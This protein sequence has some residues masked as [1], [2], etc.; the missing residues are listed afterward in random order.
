MQ[1]QLRSL[2][3]GVLMGGPS[4]ERAVSL[5]SGARVLESLL[6]QG[7]RATGLDVDHRIAARLAEND[8]NFA[9]LAVHGRFGEDGALQGL[10]EVAGIPYTGSGV[11]A[12]SVAMNKVA[13]KRLLHSVGVPTAPFSEIDVDRGVDVEARRVADSLGLPLVVKPVAEGSS[14]GVRIV[15]S[16]AALE[17]ALRSD[18]YYYGKVFAEKFVAGCEVTVGILGTNG[19]SRA[20]PVLELRP[21]NQFYDYEAKYT[22][23]MTEFVIP[24]ELSPAATSAVQRAA[25]TTHRTLGC[26]GM[27]RVDAIVTDAGEVSVLEVNTI[28]GLT[29]LSDLPAQAGAAGMSFDELIFEILKSAYVDNHPQRTNAHDDDPSEQRPSP[30]APA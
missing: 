29:E 15:D 9:F 11:L 4:R 7:F 20:L 27:S 22:D 16:H 8:I 1:E 12:S 18:L 10:L 6:G 26:R 23:G 13:T 28:P 24:A 3:I 17:K 19:A 21:K 5:R 2:N 25:T 14:L 30:A